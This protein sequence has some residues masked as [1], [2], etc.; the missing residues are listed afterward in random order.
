MSCVLVLVTTS[1]ATPATK[2]RAR[3]T[4][5]MHRGVLI[6]LLALVAMNPTRRAIAQTLDPAAIESLQQR[7]YALVQD[8]WTNGY[9]CL[10]PEYRPM[11]QSVQAAAATPEAV[12]SSM[13][14][15][16]QILADSQQALRASQ[17]AD[18]HWRFLGKALD[19][20]LGMLISAG[21]NS[22]GTVVAAQNLFSAQGFIDQANTM[23]T[24][25]NYRQQKLRDIA[26]IDAT[27]A[28]KDKPIRFPGRPDAGRPRNSPYA[29]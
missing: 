11:L 12:R 15:E 18:S 4:H 2:P 8:I 28:Q 27:I 23:I 1:T 20:M 29:F 26:E 22:G 9:T 14:T 19:S 3:M 21:A 6:T 16:Q 17:M 24:C 13:V 5:A 25:T 10:K 7:R